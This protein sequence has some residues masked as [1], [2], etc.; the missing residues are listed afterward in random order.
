MFLRLRPIF[1]GTATRAE[2]GSA[3]MAVI[4]LMAVMAVIAL[5]VTG[6]TLYSLGFTTATRAG[7]QS[8]AAAESGINM[9]EVSLIKGTCTTPYSLPDPAFTATVSYSLST[10]NDVWVGGC[11]GSGVPA[12]RIKVE[13]TGTALSTG[14]SNDDS[15]DST[16]VEAIFDYVAEVPPGVRASGAAMYMYGGVQFKNNANILVAESGRAAI[17][18]K[19]GSVVCEN[20]SVIEGDVVVLTGSLNIASCAIEGNAW[21]SGAVTLGHVTGNL[22][23]GSINVSAAVLPTRVGG[24]Y[25]RYTNASQ[26]PAVPNWVD[27]AFKPA[28]WLDSNGDPYKVNTMGAGCTINATSLAAAANGTKPVIINSIPACPLG[29][30]AT[31]TV[32]ITNDVVIF[33][34]KFTFNNNV[35]FKSSTSTPHKV[36]FITPDNVADNLPTCQASQGPF[37]MNNSFDLAP[38]ISAMVYTP[39]FFDAKNAFNWR[40][41]LY[42]NGPNVFKNSTQFEAT[43]MGLPGI[44]L[45]TGTVIPGGAAGSDAEMGDLTSMRDLT[46]GG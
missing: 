16:V 26:I 42:V 6:V 3:L 17:Q 28:D 11:P 20:N 37:S 24:V 2:R 32:N 41:Q 13:S 45:D 9:A 31:G 30:G 5:T 14:V 35:T 4:G 23:A 22:T 46:D 8:V 44:D 12:V 40:G 7:I 27:V 38:T 34:Q 39:C 21:A 43:G 18:V 25:T 10:T 36:W 15:G 33:A 19:N 1:S 29:I